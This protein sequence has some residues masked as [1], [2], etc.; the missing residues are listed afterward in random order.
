MPGSR[1][2]A[3]APAGGR[4]A[5]G[6]A[7]VGAGPAGLAAAVTAADHGL[8]VTVVDAAAAPG[9]QYFRSLPEELA[10]VRPGAAPHGQRVFDDL[11]TRLT[12]HRAAGRV[13]HVSGHHVWTVA[14]TRDGWALHTVTGQGGE[15]GPMVL[16]R[17][18]LL[19]TGAYERQLPFP[20][21]TMPG[22]V[23][24]AGAQAMLKSG[25]VLPGRRVVV[26]G[27]GP[28]LQAVAVSLVHAGARVPAL[29]EAA[30]YG[31]YARAPR[32]LAANPA[33][34]AEGIRHGAAL[35]RAGVRVMSHSAVTAV[36]GADRVEAVTVSRVD[37]DWRP[38]PGSGRTLVCDALAVGHG[39]TPQLELAVEIGCDTTAQADGSPALRLDAR[40]RTSV[41]GVWAAGEPGGI[42]GVA[43][44]LVEGEL[45]A[46][47]VAAEVRGGPLRETAGR[48]RSLRRARRAQRAFAELMGAVHRPGPGWRD[49]ADDDTEVCRCEEVTAGRI[50]TAVTEL[51]ASDARTVKLF[52]RAGMGWCQGRTCGFAV[53]E[54][55]RSDI[56]AAR[57]PT[58]DR[59]MP[60]CPVLL[61]AL[62]GEDTTA[63]P[64][65][66]P[67]A[68]ETPGTAAPGGNGGNRRP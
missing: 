49:W 31:G 3:R 57:A 47:A 40:L 23:G 29:V 26:A 5:T 63:D 61:S 46:H 53:H 39:L 44:A 20:G 4:T 59:R 19:A 25:L 64:E 55:A 15:G 66:A 27:S 16:A 21:W 9:G 12:A 30:G 28:L 54:L 65:G 68:P 11:V 8:D 67:G 32:V 38:V 13:R 22:V 58:P 42:G 24:A 41:G 14:R 62:A 52:T 34:L 36:H 37:R 18:I 1:S 50:R 56:D 2:E 51:G 45:A 33:K 17:R 7:V 10:A 35:A 60:A 48:V 43:L 6:L